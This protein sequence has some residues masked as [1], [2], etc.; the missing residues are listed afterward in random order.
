MQ[1][2][3]RR[4]RNNK[5]VHDLKQCQTTEQLGHFQGLDRHETERST[6]KD[7]LENT[8]CLSVDIKIE[9]KKQIMTPITQPKLKHCLQLESVQGHFRMNSDKECGVRYIKG[10]I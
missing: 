8:W 6:A 3:K 9:G 7:L 2:L 1:M 5:K 10:T 4:T